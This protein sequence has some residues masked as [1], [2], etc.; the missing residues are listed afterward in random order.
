MI[1]HADIACVV[2]QFGAAAAR[3]KAAGFDA[4][5]IHG[6][7]G[8]LISSFISPRGNSRT[9]EYGGGLEN[10]MRF[11]LE[12]IAAVRAAVGPGFPVW[13]KLDSREIGREGGITLAN[14]IASA[15]MVEAAGVDAITVTAYHN[16]SI[17]KLHSA[18]NIPHEPETNLEAASAIKAAVKI[19]VIASGRIEPEAADRHID[20]G[21][22][23]F[24]AMGRKLLADPQLPRKLAEGR[25][26]DVRP[27]IYCYTCVS[28]AYVREPLRCAVNPET[29]FECE[30]PSHTPAGGKRY[31]VIG[32]GPGGIEAACRLDAVGNSVVLL[33]R[34]DKLGGTLRF[35]GLAYPPNQR[36][37]EW[38][39]RRLEQS[40]VDVR[41]SSEASVETLRDL[42]PDAVVVATG[43]VRGMPPIPGG[44]LP[45]VLSGDDFRA[46][47]SGMIAT[48]DRETERRQLERP[49]A[50]M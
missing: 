11:P 43:A 18:S 32:G 22:Y 23:D 8:Y 26:R 33:E 20:E 42:D 31:V 12:V 9:D 37:L 25:A 29:G 4:I 19:P 10:R 38:L 1:D 39:I 36:L 41:L 5:E 21:R 49:L 35:A 48:N 6:G 47:L 34:S 27:C 15:R 46:M 17:G 14:A 30:R 7:H 28:T 50:G 16:T 40:G 2:A 3:A 45:H 24:L 13:I 44:E